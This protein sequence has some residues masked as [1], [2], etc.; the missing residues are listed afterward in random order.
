VSTTT[1]AETSTPSAKPPPRKRGW[2]RRLFKF[3][4]WLVLLVILAAVIA[5][6]F[7]PR[8]VRWYVNRTLSQ[9]PLY[10]GKIGDVDL[11]L[12]RGAYSIRD[13]RILKTTGNIPVPL[14]AAKELELSIEWPALLHR[15]VVGQV[16]MV[17]PEINFVDSP[18]PG[19]SE[20]GAGGPWL[21][22]LNDL[23]PFDINSFHLENGS[24][25][26]RTY[27]RAVP[28]DVYLSKLDLQ[29]HDLTN[30]DRSVTPMLT[31]VD[32]KAL[33]MDQA[34]LEMHMKLNPFSYNPT[35]HMGLRLL[36]LDVTKTNDL[37]ETYG[38][39]TVKRGMFDLVLDVDCDEGQLTGYVKPLFRDM[40]VF[41]LSDLKD[42]DPL[43]ALWQAIVG[44]ATA[45]L[46]NYN[47]DQFGTLIPFTGELKG[48]QID[49]LGTIGNVLRNAFIRAYLP[50]LEQGMPHDQEFQ[51][52]APSLTDPMSAGDVP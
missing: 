24:V 37:I 50:R 46:T 8:V 4:C 16:V 6:P 51:F 40:I 28:V 47:R 44:G 42:D 19:E 13:V 20:T 39:F 31:T 49:F 11:H 25:H 41:D 3:T 22:M 2:V 9:S 12:W 15:R 34:K 38:Q 43:R 35:F 32:A 30:I 26:F 14:F 21:K 17:E 7:L 48:P 23:F 10:Q 27:Q 29:V 52:G 1:D 33:A 18:E 36:G 45:I 5:R